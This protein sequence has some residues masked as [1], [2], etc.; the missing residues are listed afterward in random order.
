MDIKF[1]S[2]F[3]LIMIFSKS[4]GQIIQGSENNIHQFRVDLN[5]RSPVISYIPSHDSLLSEMSQVKMELGYLLN[6]SFVD[7]KATNNWALKTS[8]GQIRMSWLFDNNIPLLTMVYDSLGNVIRKL[9][10]NNDG[11]L[12]YSEG[13][14]TE[15]K[16]FQIQNKGWMYS[17]NVK[18][19][20]IQ[21]RVEIDDSLI[22]QT[23]YDNNC[24]SYITEKYLK[25]ENDSWF[26]EGIWILNL[27]SSALMLKEY[28]R[29][30]TLV[31]I[32]FNVNGIES[33]Y[34]TKIGETNLECLNSNGK[35][36]FT[37]TIKQGKKNGDWNYYNPKTGELLKQ[38]VFKSGVLINR[39]E[40]I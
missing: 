29:N 39:K 14:T 8:S 22:R 2:S 36:V 17:Q 16:E 34:E 12:I 7:G 23:C 37:G 6:F 1:I 19:E 15:V 32:V 18:G 24:D 21:V 10:R 20:K 25:N 27:K 26:R 5:Y 13:S 31:E 33:R 11:E 40:D 4:Y 9:I 30:D 3:L 38:D 28:Y 35:L